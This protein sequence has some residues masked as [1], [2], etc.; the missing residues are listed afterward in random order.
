[1]VVRYLLACQMPGKQTRVDALWVCLF[2]G[3]SILLTSLCI[4]LCSPTGKVFSD[5]DLEFI[6]RLCVKYNTYAV[7]DEA[8][9]S[10]LFQM[11]LCAQTFCPV[12]KQVCV[13]FY[14]PL[15][16]TVYW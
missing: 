10:V 9:A 5:E 7:C 13:W 16:Y 3:T 14:V 15:L 8:R 1:M 12:S 11:A 2:L 6:A 4:S